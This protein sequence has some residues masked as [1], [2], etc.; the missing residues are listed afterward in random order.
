MEPAFSS[1]SKAFQKCRKVIDLA[2]LKE[3]DSA[4]SA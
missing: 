2:V 1:L 4:V 3:I